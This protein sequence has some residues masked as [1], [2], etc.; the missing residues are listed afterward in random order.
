MRD[1]PDFSNEFIERLLLPEKIKTDLIDDENNY[2]DKL[3]KA[4]KP[5]QT[6]EI[7]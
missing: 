1:N 5:K 2:I 7:K 4:N 3:R 6:K